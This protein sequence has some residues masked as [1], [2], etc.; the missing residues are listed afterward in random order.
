[1]CLA[2]L[3]VGCGSSNSPSSIVSGGVSGTWSGDL[4]VEGQTATMTWTLTQTG[5]DVSGRVVLALTSGVVLLNGTLTG[6]L[7]GSSLP[8]TIMVSPGGIPSQTLCSG[9][10]GGT[11]TLATNGARPTLAGS[12][13][14]ISSNC[15]TPI[16]TGSFTLTRQ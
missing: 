5:Q 16:S 6:T 11:A 12:Y 8:F 9:Q 4:S 15:T 3:V 14:I 10:L 13:S 7:T 2:L 1:M